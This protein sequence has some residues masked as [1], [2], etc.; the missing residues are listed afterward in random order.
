MEIILILLVCSGGL[1]KHVHFKRSKYYLLLLQLPE[2]VVFSFAQSDN[3][4]LNFN[5]F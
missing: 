1:L 4:S 2:T 5:I 3:A